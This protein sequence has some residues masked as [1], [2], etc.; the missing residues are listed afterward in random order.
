[1]FFQSFCTSDRSCCGTSDQTYN[2]IKVDIAALL[3]STPKEERESEPSTFDSEEPLFIGNDAE[4]RA[5]HERQEAEGKRREDERQRKVIEAQIESLTLL[6]AV[7][8]NRNGY[9]SPRQDK[10]VHTEKET[11]TAG[12]DELDLWLKTN[13]LSGVNSKTGGGFM[14]T[15]Y[16][17]H[18]AVT[19]SDARVVELLLR[20]GANHKLKNSA[21]QTPRQLAMKKNKD[22]SHNSVLAALPA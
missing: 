14:R 12:K 13:E 7:V 8:D 17:L 1:M 9:S 21:M 3:A 2:K 4:R 6:T 18:L 10:P 5:Q 15:A 22:G 11:D 20:F 16:P 19:Q